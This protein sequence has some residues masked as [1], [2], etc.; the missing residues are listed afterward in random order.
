MTRIFIFPL[1]IVFAF[2][3]S[4]ITQPVDYQRSQES[5]ESA[6][7]AS[8][9]KGE[10]VEKPFKMSRPDL[11]LDWAI[12]A[13]PEEGCSGIEFAGGKI[14][15]DGNFTHLG[16]S[17]ID[18]SAAWDIGNLLDAGDEQFEPVGPAGGPVAPLLGQG[19]YPYDFQFDPFD[20]ECEQVVSATGELSLVAANGDEVHGNVTGGET[21]RLDFTGPD[22]VVPGSGV[23]TFAIIDVD[24]G[25]GRFADAEGSF[26]VHTITRFDFVARAFV[27]DLAEVL[28]NGRIAY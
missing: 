27:I 17:T 8:G 19:E 13:A 5:L 26:I 3:C 14:S 20:Q 6:A 24:G 12:E 18:M 23:E 9:K 7:E 15:G 28:P 11:S 2:G 10:D 1:L 21:H 4:D 16:R 25:T 22:G